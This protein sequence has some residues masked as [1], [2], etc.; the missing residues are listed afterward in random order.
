ML[1]I[2]W[3]VF[4]GKGLRGCYLGWVSY[5][6]AVKMKKYRGWLFLDRGKMS[7]MAGMTRSV[8]PLVVGAGQG[9]M[10]RA[11][12][13]GANAQKGCAHFFVPIRL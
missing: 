7:E 3:K 9:E 11:G 6:D 12:L 8:R 10:G 1:S 5:L 4:L 2:E 13:S